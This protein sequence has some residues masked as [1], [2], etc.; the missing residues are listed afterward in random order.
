[1]HDQGDDQ[2]QAGEAQQA[3]EP[4]ETT[5]R[6]EEAA[7]APDALGDLDD[8]LNVAPEV[9]IAQSLRNALG[10]MRQESDRISSLGTGEEQVEAAEKFAEQAGELDEQI[11][12]AARA[13]DDERR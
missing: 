5:E 9:A 11:A 3:P 6:P 10:N 13:D 4:Q 12:S 7:S 2:V 1:M 8:A